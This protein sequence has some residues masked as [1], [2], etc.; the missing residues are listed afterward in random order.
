MTVICYFQLLEQVEN[1]SVTELQ[2]MFG[3]DSVKIT[4]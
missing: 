3:L 1:L 4:M 2:Y